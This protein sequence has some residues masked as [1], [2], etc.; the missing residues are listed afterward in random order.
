VGKMCENSY[1]AGGGRQI[2]G[3]GCYNNPAEYVCTVS[4]N[5]LESDT[6]Y[7]CKSCRDALRADAKRN[8]YSFRS[9]RLP[10]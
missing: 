4:Y 8:S 1:V 5:D 6:L 2:V 7:L 9:Q 3:P 10:H